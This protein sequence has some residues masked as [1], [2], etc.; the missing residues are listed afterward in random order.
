MSMP[1]A[2]ATSTQTDLRK[3]AVPIVVGFGLLFL[4]SNP[5]NRSGTDDGFW[6]ARQSGNRTVALPAIIPPLPLP[7]LMGLVFNLS[8]RSNRRFEPTT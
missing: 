7:P 2:P 6:Y 1:K 5:G 3:V 8:G 4:L